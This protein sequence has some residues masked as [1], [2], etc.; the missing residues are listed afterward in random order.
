MITAA[1]QRRQFQ[2]DR[3]AAA[4]RRRHYTS[5]VSRAAWRSRLRCCRA[6]PLRKA[7]APR[8]LR[9]RRWSQHADDGVEA[10]SSAVADDCPRADEDIEAACICCSHTPPRHSVATALPNAELGHSATDYIAPKCRR[11]CRAR[12][13][14]WRVRPRQCLGPHKPGVY[15]RR[16][17]PLMQMTTVRR[18][19]ASKLQCCGEIG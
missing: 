17:K 19:K 4:I 5:A 7:S 10:A 14:L 8:Q 12:V 13:N 18:R 6:R 9:R 16:A 3:S 1:R 2:R 15:N 11:C